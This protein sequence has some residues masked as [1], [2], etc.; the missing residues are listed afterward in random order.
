[1]KINEILNECKKELDDLK[2]PYAKGI[3]EVVVNNKL[4]TTIAR[5]CKDKGRYSI[6]VSSIMTDATATKREV[7][8]VLIHELLHSVYGA[9]AHNSTWYSYVDKVNRAYGYDI[10][11]CGSL[12]RFKVN[13][14]KKHGYNYMIE[15]TNCGAKYYSKQ[16]HKSHNH[17]ERCYCTDCKKYAL[18]LII[19]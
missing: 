5:C 14:Y 9:F 18:K 2:I 8:Q 12:A 3:N 1:M 7:K 19:L 4:S 11:R 17:L 15:C 16:K 10:A 6:E 13:D